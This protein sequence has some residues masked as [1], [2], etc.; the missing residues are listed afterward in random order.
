MLVLYLGKRIG[1]RY[2]NDKLM[3]CSV[4]V[5]YTIFIF[6]STCVMKIMKGLQLEI[7]FLC[8]M[9]IITEEQSTFIINL[10]KLIKEIDGGFGRYG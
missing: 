6:D 1:Q 9:M 5:I 4:N 7:V 3:E 10:R 2:K 8:T